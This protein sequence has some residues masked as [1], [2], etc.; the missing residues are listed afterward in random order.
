MFKLVPFLSYVFV[1]TFTPGPNNILSLVNANKFGYKKTVKFLLGIFTGFI[2]IL[3][4]SSYFNLLLFKI[5]PKIKIYMGLMGAAYMTYL[6]VKLITSKVQ[7]KDNKNNQL[8]TFYTGVLL[9]FVNPKVILYGI[10][11][12]SNFI[13]PYYKSNISLLLFSIFL[14]AVAFVSTSLWALF[15]MAFREFLSKHERPFNIAMGL[16]LIYSAYTISGIDNIINT[17]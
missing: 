15:G 1:M 12:M 13:I 17:I 6:A 3:L 5:I 14:A 10:T 4:L 11:V 2:V 7:K 9:Q 16:L 8:N